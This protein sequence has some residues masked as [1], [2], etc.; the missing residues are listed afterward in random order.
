MEHNESGMAT[1]S[2]STRLAISTTYYTECIE[3]G[4]PTVIFGGMKN[5]STEIRSDKSPTYKIV[6]D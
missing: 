6:L 3:V 1:V 5:G 4:V 2:F